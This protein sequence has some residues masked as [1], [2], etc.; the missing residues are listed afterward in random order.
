MGVESNRGYEVGYGALISG[1]S[2]MGV[3]LADGERAA[4]YEE[5]VHNNWFIFTMASG[6]IKIIDQNSDVH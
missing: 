6:S 3:L 1:L 4:A 2:T 5:M